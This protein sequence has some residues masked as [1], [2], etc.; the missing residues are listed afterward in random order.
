MCC[1][2]LLAAGCS[3]PADGTTALPIGRDLAGWDVLH[4]T[5]YDA[6]GR[7]YVEDGQLVLS[8]GDDL[9]GVRWA[10]EVPTDNYE[11]T[12]EARRLDG[13]DF[14]C[15][16]TFPIDDRHAT[17]ILGGFGGSAVGIS[18][19][20]DLSAEENETSTGMQFVNGRWY[21]VALR[22]AAGRL[23]VHIDDEKL[24]DLK[25][26]GKRFAVWP[27]QE[28]ARPLGITTWRTTGAVRNVKLRRL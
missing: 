15:G 4:E 24:I 8:A 6:A 16:L 14:F 3:P 5:Y 9:T 25:T 11:L 17:L 20:D 22:L 26:A 28:D 13:R 2:L 1:A 7:V 18:N 19:V 23:T 21:R 12:L 10:G 27:Q